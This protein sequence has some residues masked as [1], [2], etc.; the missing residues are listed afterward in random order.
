MR[1]E[2]QGKKQGPKPISRVTLRTSRYYW[3][4]I[5]ELT[6]LLKLIEAFNMIA[7]L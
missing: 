7:P 5:N 2:R 6:T 3:W 4:S 1:V